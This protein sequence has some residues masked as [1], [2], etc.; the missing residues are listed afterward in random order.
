M[1]FFVNLILQRYNLIIYV[2]FKV[3]V[4]KWLLLLVSLLTMTK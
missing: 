4:G 1:S 3:S 2:F